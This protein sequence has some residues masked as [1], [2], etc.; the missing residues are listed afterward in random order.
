MLRQS[1]VAL[2]K[3]ELPYT[4]ARGPR[5]ARSCA[6]SRRARVRCGDASRTGLRML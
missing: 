3:A 2:A 1:A 5:A 6:S 4:V